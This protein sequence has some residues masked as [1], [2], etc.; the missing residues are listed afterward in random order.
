M[1]SSQFLLIFHIYSSSCFQSVSTADL[2]VTAAAW[3]LEPTRLDLG[4]EYS[5]A[6]AAVGAFDAAFAVLQQLL[7]F[8]REN[9]TLHW[10]FAKIESARGGDALPYLIATVTVPRAPVPPFPKSIQEIARG[11]LAK[12]LQSRGAHVDIKE[13]FFNFISKEGPSLHACLHLGDARRSLGMLDSAVE[14]YREAI[15]YASTAREA[16]NALVAQSS[17]EDIAMAMSAVDSQEQLSYNNMGIC[18]TRMKSVEAID[19]YRKLLLLISPEGPQNALKRAATLQN[20]A[21]SYQQQTK[22]E[23]AGETLTLALQLVNVL[24]RKEAGSV[25]F[26]LANHHDDVGNNTEAYVHF[27][28]A[29][30]LDPSLHITYFRRDLSF[31]GIPSSNDSIMKR[32]VSFA[33][34]SMNFLGLSRGNAG[35]SLSLQFDGIEVTVNRVHFFVSYAGLNDRVLVELAARLYVRACPSLNAV[36]VS[37]AI[38][39]QLDRLPFLRPFALPP[40]LPHYPNRLITESV[41]ASLPPV[42]GL[43]KRGDDPRCGRTVSFY[44]AEV[45]RAPIRVG[46][47]SFF[48]AENE[49]HGKV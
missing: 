13:V 35:P 37:T 31:P 24:P 12:V 7:H 23:E 9:E 29:I 32:R 16:I 28:R 33:V 34:A 21:I 47:A 48:F 49:S 11:L 27:T 39:E 5:E 45:H 25:H 18:Y 3:R 41:G 38:S 6:L 30:E 20:L 17:V 14:A 19:T 42:A 4:V 44:P 10:T 36:L 1:H 2:H 46:F 15:R 8:H 22:M 40:P 43:F 26:H